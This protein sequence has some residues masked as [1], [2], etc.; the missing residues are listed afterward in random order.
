MAATNDFFPIMR[1]RCTMLRNIAGK[2]Y[3]HNLLKVYML[4]ISI[5]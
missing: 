2:I 3:R 1:E 4:F 5:G